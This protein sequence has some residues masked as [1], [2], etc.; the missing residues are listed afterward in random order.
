MQKLDC[1]I[2]LKII[3]QTIASCGIQYQRQRE[4]AFSLEKLTY[5]EHFCCQELYVDL[6]RIRNTKSY[7][8]AQPLAY[9]FL[10]QNVSSAPFVVSNLETDLGAVYYASCLEAKL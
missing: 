5:E 9:D 7:Q 6:C 2:S 10:E 4:F 1:V 8:I 3:A